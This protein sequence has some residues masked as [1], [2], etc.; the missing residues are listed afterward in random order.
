MIVPR[1]PADS[2]AVQF[3]PSRSASFQEA[4]GLPH[5]EVRSTAA[6]SPNGF[7]HSSASRPGLYP[8]GGFR[9]RS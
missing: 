8:G 3:W 6:L 4:S 1:E 2:Q 5:R 9:L 7:G